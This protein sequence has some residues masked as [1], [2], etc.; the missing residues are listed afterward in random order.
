MQVELRVGLDEHD[1]EIFS[2][3]EAG[4]KLLP[5][6]IIVGLVKLLPQFISKVLQ[7]DPEDY[8]GEKDGIQFYGAGFIAVDSEDSGQMERAENLVVES[9]TIPNDLS[10]LTEEI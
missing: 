7:Q 10:E 9:T 4:S 2:D 5:K 1:R 8:I 6:L 3:V